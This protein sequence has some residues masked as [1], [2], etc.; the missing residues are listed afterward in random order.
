M[1]FTPPQ[2]E[3]LRDTILDAFDENALNQMVHYKLGLSLFNIVKK[4][5]LRNV[6]YELIV[7]AG[8]EGWIR[9]LVFAILEARRENQ[10][11][12]DFCKAHASWAFSPPDPGELISKVKAGIGAVTANKGDP[13]IQAVIDQF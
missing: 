7:L 8:R 12:I 10:S 13:A 6:A 2:E 1:L 3:Q 5:A 4:D 11:V 9:S